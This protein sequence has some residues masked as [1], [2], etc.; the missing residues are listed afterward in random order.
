KGHCHTRSSCTTADS[1]PA[2][3]RS[4][5]PYL[6]IIAVFVL[7]QLGPVA[8][9]LDAATV[10]F[11][12]PGLHILDPTGEPLSRTWFEFDWLATAGTLL[13]VSRICTVPALRISACSATARYG[14]T[15]VRLRGSIVTVMA[16]LAI[17]YVMNTSGQ[18]A[19]LG[20]WM[21]AVGGLFVLI[22][23]VL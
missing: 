13:L 4:Y 2:V 14:E 5:A 6:I 16:V 23:P 7:A 17:A 19:T 9:A 15:Y 20:N 8:E 3:L 12:W 22:S 18:P 10:E 11:A 1:G 21:A